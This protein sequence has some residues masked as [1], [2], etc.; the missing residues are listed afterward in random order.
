M[1][2]RIAKR[3]KCIQRKEIWKREKRKL[4]CKEFK[5]K[6]YILMQ[7]FFST[8]HKVFF[9]LVWYPTKKPIEL[10]CT[11]FK[12]TNRFEPSSIEFKDEEFFVWKGANFCQIE[13]NNISEKLEEKCSFISTIF[14]P[15]P[16][17]PLRCF[18]FLIFFP[19]F[20]SVFIFLIFFIW[21]RKA[22]RVHEKSK[23]LVATL[24]KWN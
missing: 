3:R 10:K 2:I 19:R 15:F 4:K 16:P 18:F 24:L 21:I 20:S 17:L 9:G 1:V 5:C 12:A 14:N 8:L 7:V 13:V 23:F 6:V 11:S 22:L